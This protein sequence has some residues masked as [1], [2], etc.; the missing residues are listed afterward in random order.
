MTSYSITPMNLSSKNVNS[1]IWLI[2]LL[3][4]LYFG[5]QVKHFLAVF[6]FADHHQCQCRSTKGSREICCSGCFTVLFICLYR[7]Y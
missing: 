7:I 3:V 5:L 1:Q 6:L 4:A 2:L